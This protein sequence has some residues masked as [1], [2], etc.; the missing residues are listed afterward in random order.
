MGN[1]SSLPRAVPEIREAIAL[2][3]AWERSVNDLNA[4]RRFTEAVQLLDDYLECEP[5]SPHRNFIRNLRLSNT[6]MLLRQLAQVDKKDFSLWLEYAVS[7]LAVVDKEADSVIAAN[8]GL[9][10][11]LDA[12]LNV[13]GDVIAQALKRV[14]NGEG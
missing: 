7:V 10:K 4:A 12:F 13:W 6:R 8:P 2:F 5:Q 9:Q 1:E 3:E 11:D 14:Q